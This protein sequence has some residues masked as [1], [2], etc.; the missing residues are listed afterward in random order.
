M[1]LQVLDLSGAHTP[2]P[3][4]LQVLDLS[5]AR[6]AARPRG[7][8]LEAVIARVIRTWEAGR[9]VIGDGDRIVQQDFARRSSIYSTCIT[10]RA[11]AVGQM[12]LA[13]QRDGKTVDPRKDLLAEVI[14]M[15]VRPAPGQPEA[16]TQTSLLRRAESDVWTYGEF[17]GVKRRSGKDIVRE[18]WPLRVEFAECIPNADGSVKHWL[19]GP[20]AFMG[21]GK[22]IPP[23]DIIHLK[24]YNN[25]TDYRGLSPVVSLNLELR[26]D[27]D[28]ILYL[29]ELFRNGGIPA[30]ILSLMTEDLVDE[31]T[32]DFYKKRWREVYGRRFGAAGGTGWGEIG[33]FGKGAKVDKFGLNPGELDLSNVFRVSES[34]VCSVTQVP[35]LLAGVSVGNEHSAAYG[36]LRETR[37]SWWFEDVM[38]EGNWITSELTAQLAREFGEE[39]R[40][41]ADVSKVPALKGARSQSIRDAVLAFRSKLIDRNT[42]LEDL[43][44]LDPVDDRPIYADE[45]GVIPQ[46]AAPPPAGESAAA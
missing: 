32:S 16:L 7:D 28:A 40:I 20:E 6:A 25:R 45:I 19:Y 36:H 2:H 31:E 43:M 8:Q 17:V 39:Y 13:V 29:A 34:R 21:R 23:E 38:P 24:R 4:G 18:V 41:R 11:V 9:P 35:A 12:E 10:K 3:S 15:P 37:W 22:E 46:G 1:G 33:V 5:S 27:S 30:A 14:A 26:L 42:A 44:D